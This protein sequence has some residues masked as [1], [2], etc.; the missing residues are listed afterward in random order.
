MPRPFHRSS[1]GFTLIELLVVIAIIAVLI[2]LLIP[3]VQKVRE[4]AA[5]SKC[6][7]N[8]KQVGLALHHFHDVNGCFPTSGGY[9]GNGVATPI[10]ATVTDGTPKYWGVG[11]PRLP[12]RQQTGPWAYSILPQ[13]E[14]SAAYQNRTF[15]V[16]VPTYMCPSRGRQNPQLVPDVDPLSPNHAFISGGVNPWG[17]TDYAANP[18]IAIGN[19]GNSARTGKT[20]NFDGITDGTSNTILAGEKSLDPRAYDTG[21]WLWDE[22][23]F[24]GGGAGGTVR[25]GTAVLRDIPGVNFVDTW[26]SPHTSGC[27]FLFADGSVRSIQF[28]TAES[29]MNPLLT[30]SGGEVPPNV[31][32]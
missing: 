17:K 32:N 20:L 21:S 4:A 29:V 7:N 27:Q 18:R 6:Q 28:E 11:D 3:A 13:L 24:A 14:M 2:G 30:P 26:G 23:I 5:R 19:T 15:A 1:L 8:L 10:I 9:P 31:G 25:S 16:A 12:V 22:P